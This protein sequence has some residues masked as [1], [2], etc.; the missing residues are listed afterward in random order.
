[1]SW[2]LGVVQGH[3]AIS[4]GDGLLDGRNKLLGSHLH[5]LGYDNRSC[6]GVELL[7]GVTSDEVLELGILGEQLGYAFLEL[8]DLCKLAKLRFVG[9]EI[10]IKGLGF[11]EGFGFGNK[12]VDTSFKHNTRVC[13][14]QHISCYK[15]EMRTYWLCRPY[16]ARTSSTRS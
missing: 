15:K 14:R 2:A 8:G 12:A 11:M 3:G 13:V 9:M 1:M 4:C 6:D 5:G 16:C 10:G 7:G